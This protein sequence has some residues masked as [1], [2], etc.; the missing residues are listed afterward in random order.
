MELND[1]Q[2][3]GLD[4]AVDRY[5]RKERYTVISGYAGTGKSTLVK[6][7]V[8]ALPNINPDE[9]VIYT[10]F[11]G[12]A[13]QVLQKKGNKNVSTLHKL[14]FESIPKPDGTFFRK[15]VEFI[16]YKI[17][18]VDECSMVPKELLQRLIKYNVHIICLGDPGQLPPINKNEDNHLLDH[19]HIFLDEIMRQEAESEIINLT[20]DIR[21]GKPLT[22]YQGKEV[23]VLNKDELTT[24]MLLWADQ[25]ICAKNETRIALN[26]Q[27]RD[28]LGRSG[29]PQDGDKVICL[30]NN[31][32]IYSVNDN[33]LVNGTIGYLKDSFST[34]INLPRQITS[35]GQPKKLDILTANFI[36]DT[37]EDY[38]ILNMDKQLITTGVPGLD[39]KTSYKMGRNWRFQDKIPDQFT[40]GY[41]ITCHKSQGSEWDN[42]LVIEEGFPF[43]KEEHKQ[44]LYTAA[45]RAAKKLVIIKKD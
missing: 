32:D 38:G 5:K 20:M 21:A 14:L 28:L 41:A 35:D 40:Y 37:E 23:Q 6:F 16:P 4:I 33:P 25:I 13:T 44:W 7:I 19:P 17:V 24:G 26:N 9:D 2:K 1:K 18:I 29:G 39:W 10:S 30:K 27:M 45:T 3:Q 43:E 36:S 42:V 11:T 8:A 31:W 34:Y 15:P 22:R 12:K